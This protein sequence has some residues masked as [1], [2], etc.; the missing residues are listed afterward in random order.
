MHCAEWGSVQ[1]EL[2]TARRYKAAPQPHEGS[3]AEPAYTLPQYVTKTPQCKHMEEWDTD[4]LIEPGKRNNNVLF[5]FKMAEV[6][7]EKENSVK[8]LQRNPFERRTLQE[9][10][11]I[12]ELGPDKPD[13]IITQKNKDRGRE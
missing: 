3:T 1:S 7:M 5:I 10:I 12:K 9:K 11:R 6:E 2:H 13:V 8:S 4:W